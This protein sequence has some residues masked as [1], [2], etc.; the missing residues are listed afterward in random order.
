MKTNPDHLKSLATRFS[1]LLEKEKASF[2]EAFSSLL[3]SIR[4]VKGATG[5]K[6]LQHLLT[7]T[8]KLQESLCRTI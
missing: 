7:Q 2:D 3:E 1:E 6:R 4:I 5:D 8:K